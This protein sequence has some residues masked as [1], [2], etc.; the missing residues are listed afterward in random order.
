M[1]ESDGRHGDNQSA[2]S[3]RSAALNF[4]L[5]TVLADHQDEYGVEASLVRLRRS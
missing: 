4:K 2:T 1:A 3:A 5:R